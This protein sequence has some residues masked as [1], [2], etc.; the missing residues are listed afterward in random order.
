VSTFAR[1]V[2]AAALLLATFAS[3]SALAQE[4]AVDEPVAEDMVVDDTATVAPEPATAIEIAATA[5][6]PAA[7]VQPAQPAATA[8]P[9]APA[10]A[11]GSAPAGARVNAAV[12]DNRF[13]PSALTVGVGTTVTWT[14]NG[15]NAHTLSSP[16][17]L[18]DSGGLFGGQTFS[19]T[20]D[21]AGTYTIICRQ[22]GLNGMAGQVIVQ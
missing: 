21:K 5:P 22:H 14:N 9:A 8:A 2:T 19:Y 18:F 13:Q 1:T 17:G 15:N 6:T 20:F 10:S 7:I 12:V 4:Q 16:D 11:S 3:S